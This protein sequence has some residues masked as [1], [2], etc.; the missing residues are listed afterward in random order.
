M[1]RTLTSH[2]VNFLIYRYLQESGF[3][4]TAYNFANETEIHKSQIDGK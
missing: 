1:S 2:E 3:K 4:H